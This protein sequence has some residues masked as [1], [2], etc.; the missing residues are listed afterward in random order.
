MDALRKTLSA[1][2]PASHRVWGALT[3]G[4]GALH[5]LLL[6]MRKKDRESER[7]R[8]REREGEREREREREVEGER[9]REREREREADRQ[10]QNN[11]VQCFVL[12]VIS[13][14]SGKQWQ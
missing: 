7:E 11:G 9:E 5:P 10:W 4:G 8:N 3:H 2:S 13:C 12:G 1:I 6:P 14:V